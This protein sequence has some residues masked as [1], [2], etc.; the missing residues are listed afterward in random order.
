[1]NFASDTTAPAHPRILEALARVNADPM[2]SYGADPVCARA[3]A[4][5]AE[6]FETEVSVALTASGTAT[7]ALALSLLAPPWG[8]V[9]CHEEAH[10]HRD[11]NGAPEF[12]SGGLKLIPLPG[13]GAKIAPETLKAR[14]ADWPSDFVHTPCGA[15]VTLSNLSEAGTAW[16]PDEVGG[17]AEV[18]H[19]AGLAVH[20]DG[21]R[22]ANALVS[23]RASPAE[24]TWRAG[25][26][27]LSFGASKNGALGC[28]AIVLF[29][30]HRDKRGELDRRLKR[31]GHMAPKQRYLGAQL[32]AYLADD[33]WLDLARTA[34][35]RAQALA[36]GAG[37]LGVRTRWPTQGNEVFLVL[38]DAVADRL[39]AAGA[40]F[41]PFMGPKTYRFVCA[42]TTTTAEVEAALG[43]LS[44]ALGETALGAAAQA[45]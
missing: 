3:E 28:E 14:L 30:D 4:R 39:K 1:M 6:V 12:F 19:A 15:A 44:A 18:A 7:N 10:V 2:P 36:Q 31:S 22:F 24:L 11:E 32:E 26:D 20:M 38:E 9:F 35:A 17:L 8:A 43:A 16:S 25:V 13:E 33:L 29:G 23:G 42:W 45:G 40:V 34:N 5:L 37:A 41:Y 27:V 21:A